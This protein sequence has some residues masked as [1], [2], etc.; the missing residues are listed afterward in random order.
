MTLTKNVW[1]I[2]KQYTF[3]SYRSASV[4]LH[5]LLDM[6]PNMIAVEVL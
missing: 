3:H 2:D 1:L 6:F 4:F 5:R